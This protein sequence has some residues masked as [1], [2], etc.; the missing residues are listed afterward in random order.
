MS[1]PQTRRNKFT[2]AQL[3]EQV[4]AV[5]TK[6][7]AAGLD[8]D[9]GDIDVTKDLYADFK[10]KSR[11][12][13]R[14]DNFVKKYVA[15]SKQQTELERNYLQSYRVCQS[16]AMPADWVQSRLGNI[17]MSKLNK[18]L[19]GEFYD[20]SVMDAMVCISS[21]VYLANS[22]SLSPN[23]R[24]R[25]WI[26]NLKQIGTESVSGYALSADAGYGD[27]AKAS[28]E[29][30]FIVK[31]VRDSAN[32]TELIHEV[33][34]GFSALNRLRKMVPNFAYIFG[35]FET[36][37]P[38]SGPITAADPKGKKIATFANSYGMGNDVAHAIYETIAP[39]RDFGTA[40]A[41]CDSKTYMQY[42]MATLLALH[43]ADVEC[44]FTHY[45]L[46]QENM[47]LRQ[48]TD[49]RYVQAVKNGANPTFYV[50]YDLILA[51]GTSV[52]YYVSSPGE[53]PT[54]IDYGRSHVEVDGRH[55]GMP[56]ELS[57][58]YTSQNV[59]INRSNPI[60]DAFKL[61]GMSLSEAYEKGNY[62][63]VA[64]I[65]PLLR[66]FQLSEFNVHHI[67]EARSYNKNYMLPLR[68][69][70]TDLESFIAFCARYCRALG[71]NDVLVDEPPEGAFVLTP[72]S[73]RLEM[74]VFNSVGLSPELVPVPEPKTF[75]EL[76]DILTKY[77]R[78]HEEYAERK[79]EKYMA[80]AKLMRKL[81]FTAR[82]K[83]A[84]SQL[85]HA[86]EFEID[87]ITR[88]ITNFYAGKN[89]RSSIEEAQS[90]S[91]DIIRSTSVTE[92]PASRDVFFN[93]KILSASRKYVANVAL[94][95]D[96]RQTLMVTVKAVNY[97]AAI[98]ASG[99][100]VHPE[101][102]EAAAIKTRDF[103]N[104]LFKLLEDLN[105]LAEAFDA[106]LEVLLQLFNP[107]FEN[108]SNKDLKIYEEDRQFAEQNDAYLWYYNIALT[109]PSF[110][111]P[112]DQFL[113]ELVPLS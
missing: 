56:G 24:I 22:S 4:D 48:C 2:E 35:Y 5:L 82:Q 83:F 61:L 57:Y 111:M 53:I 71:W 31:A 76:Y 100:K 40:V 93:P 90:L 75:L 110:F 98:F 106:S 79:S 60:Y 18:S 65:S 36:S 104:Y 34:C 63:L 62:Q 74:S 37:A 12:L 1:Q 29:N 58:L 55:Y 85:T 72:V 103:Y 45:D 50:P 92:L 11:A 44:G 33:F 23:D 107:N 108:K 102:Y 54:I 21:S 32:A 81:F 19:S 67:S 42:Y 94:F 73:D 17:D 68:T 95:V 80:Q 28:A 14:D 91:S 59:Y 101:L 64:E 13:T 46:H 47:L 38:V 84:T 112:W 77:A 105:P 15:K 10:E 70:V 30:A 51:D 66:H 52:R 86:F 87:K 69:N 25:N 97:A 78:R 26:R 89:V 7:R 3:S 43:I 99:A 16:D 96:L 113:L 8:I 88:V 41:T 20:S 27:S 109:V 49:A 9:Q 6:L 39:A